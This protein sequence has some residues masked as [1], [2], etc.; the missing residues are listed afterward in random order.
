VQ[1][2]VYSQCKTQLSKSPIYSCQLRGRLLL[3]S[4]HNPPQQRVLQSI[5]SAASGCNT[6]RWFGCLRHNSGILHSTSYIPRPPIL[7][8]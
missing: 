8:W 1:Y 3:G 2:M 5:Y 4:A 7:L 6:R